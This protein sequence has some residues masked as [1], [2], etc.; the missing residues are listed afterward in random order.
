MNKPLFGVAL[1]ALAFA[2]PGIAQAQRTPAAIIVTV[3]SGRITQ[4]CNACRTAVGQI[5]G[6][7]T[8]L[9]QRAQALS[10]PLD[11]EAAGI[12]TSGQAAQAMAAGAARTAAETALRTRIQAFQARQGAAQ[13]ELQRGEQNIQSIRQN[14]LRQVYDRMNPIISQVM[15]THGAN[16]ALD[17]DATLAHAPALDVTNEVLTALNTQ[18]PSVTVAPMP[19]APGAT[20]PQ[21]Q[22]R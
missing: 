11:T 14:V 10:Q 9:Q 17:I 20:T 6:M 16:L 18:L 19:Q 1:S 3:D 7:V 8:Q 13:Q 21:P 12:Q 15:T 22:G 2:T 5:Q 4:E